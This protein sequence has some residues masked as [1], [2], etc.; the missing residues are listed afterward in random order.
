LLETRSRLLH[1]SSLLLSESLTP[2]VVSVCHAIIS[3]IF[4]RHILGYSASSQLGTLCG[5]G[6]K[7]GKLCSGGAPA[8]VHASERCLHPPF[9]WLSDQCLLALVPGHKTDPG[10]HLGGHA[11]AQGRADSGQ[12]APIPL[13]MLCF[14]AAAGVVYYWGFPFRKKRMK[15]FQ[16]PKEV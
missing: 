15:G 13:C 12:L 2:S 10:P 5:G 3:P 11:A 14:S 4:L 9:H 7:P 6:L 8:C 16:S 1:L